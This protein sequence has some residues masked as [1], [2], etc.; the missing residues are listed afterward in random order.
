[1]TRH[2]LFTLGPPPNTATGA[3]GSAAL[4]L[5]VLTPALLALL[6]LVVAAG[7]VTAAHAQVDGAARDAARAASQQRS[8]PAARTAAREIAAAS[9]AGQRLT[10]RPMTVRLTGSFAAAA[11]TPA[12]LT[13]R[14]G[15]T[16]ALGDVGLPGL[17]GAKTLSADYTAVLDTYR[18]R[19]P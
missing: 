18:G 11:G 14:V 8:A 9:L 2:R 3:A 1:V 19:A 6:L 10:C 7:R 15:C 17:P 4:E 5:V 16:V 12:A 13:V